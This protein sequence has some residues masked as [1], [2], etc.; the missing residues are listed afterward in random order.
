MPFPIPIPKKS[1]II[2]SVVSIASLIA[3]AL[4]LPLVGLQFIGPSPGGTG[5]LFGVVSDCSSGNPLSQVSIKA[6]ALGGSSFSSTSDSNGYYNF[7]ITIGYA[8]AV[9]YTA[10]GYTTKT[11]SFTMI[12]ASKNIN[13]ALLPTGF[14]GACLP[15]AV[16]QAFQ[17]QD[18]STNA[19]IMGAT[20]SAT[21]QGSGSALSGSCTTDGSG[22]CVMTISQG[23]TYS[24]SVA[25]SGYTSQT[26]SLQG[27]TGGSY[28]VRLIATG[29][30]VP[31]PTCPSGTTGTPPFCTPVSKGPGPGSLL[32]ILRIILAL[33][34]VVVGIVAALYVPAPW[35]GKIGVVLVFIISAIAVYLGVLF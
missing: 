11:E 2:G 12:S 24:V 32:P 29:T 13:E 10:S 1:V 7:L 27:G 15:P 31:P 33:V 35:W 28:P 25:A 17:V 6:V 23:V 9:T 3:L 20:I 8:Y 30:T 16:R 14:T 19:Y 26:F 21:P 4:I 18:A 5:P 34:L 22:N